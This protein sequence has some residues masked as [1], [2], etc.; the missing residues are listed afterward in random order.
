MSSY[1]FCSENK[2]RSISRKSYPELKYIKTIHLDELDLQIILSRRPQVRA[3]RVIVQ[4]IGQVGRT[5][6]H[7]YTWASDRHTQSDTGHWGSNISQTRNQEQTG[8]GIQIFFCG[9][10]MEIIFNDARKQIKLKRFTVVRG[11]YSC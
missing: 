2:K 4:L 5:D 6:R 10:S 1:R 3:R 8:F 9:V 11:I 7:L